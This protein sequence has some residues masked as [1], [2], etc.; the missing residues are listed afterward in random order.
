MPNSC[1]Q[2]KYFTSY[3][4]GWILSYTLHRASIHTCYDQYR[5]IFFKF[6]LWICL[7]NSLCRIANGQISD[8]FRQRRLQWKA[9]YHG[10]IY[11]WTDFHFLATNPCTALPERTSTG[12]DMTEKNLKK[13]RINRVAV[14]GYSLMQ[15]RSGGGVVDN[16]LDYQSRGRKIDPPLLRSFGWDFKLRSRLRM[17]SLL[18]GR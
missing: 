3:S 7:W 11:G 16:T 17:T 2:S 15:Y 18:V 6:G 5:P 13:R 8:Y 10:A 14:V 1:W 12:K 9:V 4:C